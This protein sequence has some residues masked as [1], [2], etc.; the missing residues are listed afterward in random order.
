MDI[1]KK[2]EI[3]EYS[4]TNAYKNKILKE[5][6]S[7][8]NKGEVVIVITNEDKYNKFSKDEIVDIKPISETKKIQDGMTIYEKWMFFLF[9]R[10]IR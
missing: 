1:A 6:W 5:E 2:K 3:L 10:D 4:S 7:R 9:K 8:K